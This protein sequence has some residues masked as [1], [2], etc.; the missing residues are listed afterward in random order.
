M[1]KTT[2]KIYKVIVD[3]LQHDEAIAIAK[4]LKEAS[5]NGDLP[6]AIVDCIGIDDPHGKPL[7]REEWE[8][9]F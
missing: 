8:C 4:F 5:D 7:D 3:D 2:L 9:G 6:Y 1:A